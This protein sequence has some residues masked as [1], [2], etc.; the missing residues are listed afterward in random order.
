M[1]DGETMIKFL[2]RLFNITFYMLFYATILSVYCVSTYKCVN[3][4]CTNINMIMF[5]GVLISLVIVVPLHY[6][7][8]YLQNHY[9]RHQR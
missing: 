2:N 6:L 3:V 5:I 9:Q 4:D 7:F 8:V 1:G